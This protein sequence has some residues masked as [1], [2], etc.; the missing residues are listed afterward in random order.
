MA[1]T[2]LKIGD[3]TNL[4]KIL[5]ELYLPS[6]AA[7]E[8]FANSLDAGADNIEIRF[9]S[10]SRGKYIVFSD[11]GIGMDES[12]L[13][14]VAENIGNSIK[15]VENSDDVIGQFGI[16]ILGF[17]TFGDEMHIVSRKNSDDPIYELNIEK[18]NIK[19]SIGESRRKQ[20]KIAKEHGTDVYIYYEGKCH[21]VGRW[22]ADLIGRKY[23]SKLMAKK[24][25]AIIYGSKR[26]TYEIKPLQ[27]NGFHI[28]YNTFKTDLG[29]IKLDLYLTKNGS[30]AMPVKIVRKGVEICNLNEIEEFKQYPWTDKHLT[31][32]IIYNEIQIT[33]DR[34]H[35][36][37]NNLQYDLLVDKVTYVENIVKEY[38]KEEEKTEEDIDKEFKNF[39]NDLINDTI[40]QLGDLDP[41]KQK[42]PTNKHHNAKISEFGPDEGFV[43]LENKDLTNVDG[44]KD[45]NESLSN[46]NDSQPKVSD[47]TLHLD[48]EDID[49]IKDN[50]KVFKNQ[51]KNN[52]NWELNNEVFLDEPWRMSKY[53]PSTNTI[54]INNRHS[55]FLEI[56]QKEDYFI[57]NLYMRQYIFMLLAKELIM[58]NLGEGPQPFR[59][60]IE[61]NFDTYVKFLLK[62]IVKVVLY[63]QSIS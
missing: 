46:E 38:L 5:G 17:V 25:N 26:N 27:Y 35:I 53:E 52:T 42:V 58:F 57:K 63:K 50:T 51:T 40:T 44:N 41:L 31:G 34:A 15:K 23:R 36:L 47:N 6:D 49:K 43:S 2:T 48:D 28:Y 55:S 16:G 60:E 33:S 45:K 20:L 21:V 62:T 10:D 19:C 61:K 12:D 8:F 39:L 4:I 11:D 59:N 29:D 13:Y 1:E 3:V 14:H 54:F 22:L 24:V 56:D 7:A 9:S 18:G 32:E 30:D 37:Q